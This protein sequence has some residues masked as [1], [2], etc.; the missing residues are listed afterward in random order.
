MRYVL[1]G[2]LVII[3]IIIAM[4]PASL[5]K[6]PLAAVPDVQLSQLQGT[7]WGGHGKLTIARQALGSL[8]WS[9]RPAELL[10][11]R[12]A[13]DYRL[14]GPALQLAGEVGAR[15]SGISLTADGDVQSTLINQILAEYEL[16]IP[17]ALEFDSVLAEI[18]DKQRVLALA[19]Q[20]R[21]PGGLV[22]YALDGRRATAQLPAMRADLSLDDNEQPMAAI[23]SDGVN[24]PVLTL[25]L[26]DS[27]FVKVSLTRR[28]TQIAGMPW[29]GSEPDH[30]VVLEV[31]QQVF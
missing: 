21:W 30:A 28:F 11:A 2:V 9:A 6:R 27:G 1:V 24:Y 8:R 18:D 31:E 25:R 22:S 3:A 19:G 7:L 14:A 15:R 13:A 5:L 29:P 12:L 4:A 17:G 23:Y 20:L 16:S 26:L 10:Q